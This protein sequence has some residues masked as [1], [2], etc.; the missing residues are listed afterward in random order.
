MPSQS[1]AHHLNFSLKAQWIRL[2]DVLII[3]PLMIWGGVA[4]T[5]RSPVWGVILGAM[6]FGTIWFNGRNWWLIRQ[7]EQAAKQRAQLPAPA[8]AEVPQ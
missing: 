7:A 3:G 5:K 6:G 8:A 2:A 4:L 1:V